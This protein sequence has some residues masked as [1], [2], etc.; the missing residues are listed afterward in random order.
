MK[1][2][3]SLPAGVITLKKLFESYGHTGLFA[4]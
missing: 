3:N 4:D 2:V 1:R